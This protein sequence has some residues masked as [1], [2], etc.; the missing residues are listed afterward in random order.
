LVRDPQQR[1]S[2]K[3]L[4]KIL[5]ESSSDDEYVDEFYFILLKL[6]WKMNIFMRFNLKL[7]KVFIFRPI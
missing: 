6:N 3:D 1:A 7:K 2:A 4:L 5:K